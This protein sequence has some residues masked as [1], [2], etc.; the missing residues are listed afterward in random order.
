MILTV[1]KSTERGVALGV[2]GAGLFVI[3]GVI[4]VG[5]VIVGVVIAGVVIAG[6]FCSRR[7][8]T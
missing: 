3:A 8:S 1:G 7:V 6:V 2:T 5:V 4:I